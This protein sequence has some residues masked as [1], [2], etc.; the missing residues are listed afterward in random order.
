MTQSDAHKE[1][2]KLL[3]TDELTHLYN[4]R[5][6]KEQIP[7]Y[8]A[9]AQQRDL[10]V[11]FFMFDMDNFKGINDTYG[12]QTGDS[13]LVHFAK[14]LVNTF[15]KGGIPIRYAGDEFMVIS[16]GIDK[17]K[18][19]QLGEVVEEKLRNTPFNAGNEQLKL[20][21]SIGVSLFPGDG[22][23]VDTLFEKA[24]E[25]LY[26]AKHQGKGRVC[27]Y[28]D[29]G[30]LLTPEKLDSVLASP[31]IVGRD[32]ILKFIENHFSHHGD[33]RIF[34]I[35]LGKDG[36]GKTRLIKYAQKIVE[37]NLAFCLHCKGYPFWQVE[38]YGIAF[39]ALSS[40]FEKNTAISDK[41]FKELED[42]FKR[43]LKPRIYAWDN[44]EFPEDIGV[45]MEPDNVELFKA[46][47]RV[48]MILRESGKGA[49]L[50]DD[51]D[52]I[53]KASLQLF[54]AM[55]ADEESAE[56]LFL[57]TINVKDSA[58]EDEKILSLLSS[59]RKVSDN[60]ELKKFNLKPLKRE[61]IRQ[62]IAK[63]F[64]GAQLKEELEDRLLHNS[65]GNPLFVVETLSFLLQN[66]KIQTEGDKW[67]LAN[68]E[69][70]DIPTNMDDLLT[71]RLMNMDEES[72][73]VLK[74]ASILGEQINPHQLSELSG[75]KFQQVMDILGNAK[76]ALLIEE[77]PNP[78]E[79]IFAHR[80]DRSVFYSLLS[81]EEKEK[82]HAL[83]AEIEKKHSGG[84]LERVVGR[85]AY[86][87]QSAGQLDKASRL[88]SS[89]K[90]QMENV[91][92]SE[93][94][95]KI[96]QKRIITSSMAKES[97]L[98]DA[99][100][101]NAVETARAFKVAMQNLRLYPRENENV[102]KSIEKFKE[103]LDGFLGQKTEALSIS[104]TSETMVFNGQP[105]PPNKTDPK[106]TQEMYS[107]LSSYG[108]QGLLFI[109]GV[110]FDEIVDFLELFTMKPEEVA[111]RWDKIVEEKNFEHIL[112]DRK[113]FVAV[114]EHNISLQERELVAQTIGES[115]SGDAS[116]TQDE[117]SAQMLGEQQVEK[118]KKLV[119]EFKQD[120]QELIQA[121][122]SG[123]VDNSTMQRLIDLLEKST[124]VPGTK[125]LQPQETAP[126]E[127]QKPSSSE[128]RYKDVLPDVEL[129][130][131]SE[132]DIS[133]AFKDLTSPDTI[134]RAK[135]AA[136]LIKQDADKVVP[137]A[138]EVICSDTSIKVSKLA[139][140][141][142]VKMG[143]QAVDMLLK[144]IHPGM[145]EQSL[146]NFIDVADL[147]LENPN[148]LP[149]LK[150]IILVGSPGAVRKCFALLR[151][152]PSKAVNPIVIDLFERASGKMKL[153]VLTL[154]TERNIKEAIPNLVEII[155][156]V[157]FWEQE[158]KIPLQV[159]VCRALGILKSPESEDALIDAAQIHK[160]WTM[161]KTK[162]DQVR[163]TA[164]WALKQLP[165]SNRLNTLL[166][167]LKTD[168]SSAVRKAVGT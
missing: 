90:K 141:V 114:G 103:Y 46:L 19:K 156:P 71:E 77:T 43:V 21:C 12:H 148:L 137:V 145:S 107:Q 124:G 8:L 104:F 64:D 150:E 119:D 31:Y 123:K 60:G 63:V 34:P 28:P 134:T 74:L 27:I 154:I 159:Q 120:K 125:V 70:K 127:Q 164:V 135:A 98:E 53:D 158:Q 129:V 118:I 7:K 108:L 10:T 139:A 61:H 99:D 133:L 140:A 131:E 93:G 146:K 52:Q 55:F 101:A 106:L 83:A 2:L 128:E 69:T 95:R 48:L 76:R 18:A 86:H 102:K 116:S 24:D 73:N 121:L 15:K 153:E 147:F 142:V 161:L 9:Q 167:K 4:R 62:F 100:L 115:E 126:K 97:P 110:T 143:T 149:K 38:P 78:E 68:I 49:I 67:N 39:S 160:P 136:W 155:R 81:E 45:D 22:E 57:A 84:A 92:I 41:V 29:S 122:K 14:I 72:I 89:F 23:N 26:I 117:K 113:I 75:L 35:I 111:T 130:R 33:N 168:K 3:Y 54:D 25:A 82:Y 65:G 32:E 36:T 87:Y 151:R 56:I 5:Y 37:K 17:N 163:A 66:N 44:K 91:L 144:K 79:Y 30:K 6:L 112:P 50:L 162:P 85:L 96:L 20:Q 105:P 80:L 11:A 94:T 132:V 1:L 13:A 42:E 166:E 88:F 165:E 51:A 152:I 157:K 47:M 59:M 138:L 40:F 58:E 16:L 109:R